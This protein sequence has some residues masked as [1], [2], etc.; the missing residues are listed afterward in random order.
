[1]YN[2]AV[3]SDARVLH[4]V[5]VLHLMAVLPKTL[6]K[7]YTPKLYK[8]YTIPPKIIHGGYFLGP[9]SPRAGA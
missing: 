3:A 6:K 9:V 1:M 7:I 8:P 5:A 4:L 2:F